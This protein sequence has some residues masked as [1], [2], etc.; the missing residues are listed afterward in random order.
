MELWAGCAGLYGASQI[1]VCLCR[2]LRN[3][4]G[5]VRDWEGLCG[6]LRRR[7]EGAMCLLVDV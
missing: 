1:T 3:L 5:F 2:A 6:A 7:V 4:C